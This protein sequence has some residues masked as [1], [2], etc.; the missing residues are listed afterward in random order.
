MIVIVSGRK[1]FP[2]CS[3]G[4]VGFYIATLS[5]ALLSSPLLHVVT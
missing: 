3:A 4:N 5:Q 1:Y 2:M